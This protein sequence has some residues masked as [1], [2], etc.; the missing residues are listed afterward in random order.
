[1]IDLFILFFFGGGGGGW[2]GSGG[3]W[4]VRVDE[5]GKV[6]FFF[7][8]SNGVQVG[9]WGSSRG[10]RG[11]GWG[12]GLGGQGR[13]EQRSDVFVKIHIFLWGVRLGG[14]VGGVRMDV[15]EE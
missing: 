13:C 12:V 5:N 7:E 11:S 14:R 4:G 15:D 6:K 3:C 9:G 8:N 1:M 10:E 2:V